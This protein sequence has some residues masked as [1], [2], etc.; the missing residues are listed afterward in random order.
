MLLYNTLFL[1]N[2]LYGIEIL[3]NVYEDTL[4]KLVLIQKKTIDKNSQ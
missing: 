1:S 3:G 4:T 2:I